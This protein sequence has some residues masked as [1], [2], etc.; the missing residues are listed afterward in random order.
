[1]LQDPSNRR[2][3]FQYV[4]PRSDHELPA[5]F[6]N[7]SLTASVSVK[8]DPNGRNS[9]LIGFATVFC[10]RANFSADDYISCDIRVGCNS[11]KKWKTTM[12]LHTIYLGAIDRRTSDHL[13]LNYR[14]CDDLPKQCRQQLESPNCNTL[15]FSFYL[16]GTCLCEPCGVRL[17]YEEDLEKLNEITGHYNN[18]SPAKKED[19]RTQR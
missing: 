16:Y 13:F 17:V 2:K 14:H 3:E 15:E 6:I 10:F 9:K 5:W 11:S 19:M 4:L 18:E 8:L 1:M 12:K 7:Q